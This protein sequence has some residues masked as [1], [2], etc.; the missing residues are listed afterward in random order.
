MDVPPQAAEPSSVVKAAEP[1]LA[2]VYFTQALAY[3]PD[4]MSLGNTVATIAIPNLSCT[5][6]V[7]KGAVFTGRS[8]SQGW[9]PIRLPTS[10]DIVRRI[11]LGGFSTEI[12]EPEDAIAYGFPNEAIRC[13]PVVVDDELVMI[14]IQLESQMYTP[15]MDWFAATIQMAA[16]R[17]VYREQVKVLKSNGRVGE[18]AFARAKD[19]ACTLHIVGL[20]SIPESVNP[21]F[22]TLT[23]I[24]LMAGGTE[25]GAFLQLNPLLFPGAWDI[26]SRGETVRRV[27]PFERS[28]GDSWFEVSAHPVVEGSK[29]VRVFCR[30]RDVTEHLMR[31]NTVKTALANQRAD[32]AGFLHTDIAGRF[33]ASLNAVQEI[34]DACPEC[35][36][37]LDTLREVCESV[38]TLSHSISRLQ[39]PDQL[40]PAMQD[41]ARS[42]HGF[43]VVL[44]LEE[45]ALA[46][47]ESADTAN[48]IL[49]VV[50]EAL[51]NAHTHAQASYVTCGLEYSGPGVIAVRIVDDGIGM[52][53][54]L[55]GHGIRY[56]TSIARTLGGVLEVRPGA[57]GVGTE[58]TFLCTTNNERVEPC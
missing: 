14:I 9:S 51:Y 37:H 44:N 52:E 22:R 19:G 11:S 54:A 57:G 7:R 21:A 31:D 46:Q 55:P 4:L 26:L 3:A 20:G 56:M 33:L 2:S 18:I 32:I 28:N 40:E 42:V 16:E 30:F 13:L 10:S 5:V 1:L 58:I 50:R 12:I 17:A 6:M 43:R 45:A 24:N 53:G 27:V 36:G 47:V 39:E 23:G 34:A 8:T 35:L 49:N 25:K 41:L 29:L 15:M 48:G 38:R